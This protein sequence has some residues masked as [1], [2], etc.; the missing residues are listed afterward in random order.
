MKKVPFYVE[1]EK[2]EFIYASEFMVGKHNYLCA[3]CKEF[4]AVW[5]MT[6]GLLQPCRKCEKFYRLVKISSFRRFIERFFNF[7]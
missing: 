5:D 6:T 7:L 4:S 1:I 3:C 2:C